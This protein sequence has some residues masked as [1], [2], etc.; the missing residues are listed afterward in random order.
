M[1]LNATPDDGENEK[2]E[3][4]A[5]QGVGEGVGDGVGTGVGVGVGVA[6][7]AGVGV[8]PGAAVGVG[9]GDGVGVGTG[10]GVGVGAGVERSPPTGA[11]WIWA[12]AD[13]WKVTLEPP[14]N[15]ERSGVR[16]W[17]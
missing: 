4:G 14:V 15:A 5:K 6:P 12:V 11:V 2:F 8:G 9:V 17:K 16:R 1:F 13:C 10:V 3:V 7:G